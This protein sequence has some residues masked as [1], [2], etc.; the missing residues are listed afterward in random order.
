MFISVKILQHLKINC[1]HL[2]RT[3]IFYHIITDISINTAD[4]SL[5]ITR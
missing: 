5:L 2:S 4:N 1:Y 3:N